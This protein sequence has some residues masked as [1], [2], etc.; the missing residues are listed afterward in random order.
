MT[1]A[2]QRLN[3][4]FNGDH[5]KGIHIEELERQII[6]SGYSPL[7]EMVMHL[8]HEDI[9]LGYF[10]YIQRRMENLM[11]GDSLVK[12]EDGWA[13]PDGKLVL[14]FSRRFSEKLL[15]IQK[16]GFHLQEVEIGFI[17]YW[18]GEDEKKEIKIILPELYFSKM[19]PTKG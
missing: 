5:F 8:N 2:K 13:N 6:R 14:K 18:K 4:Y 1:R 16:S 19:P 7:S 9:H 3:I 15:A 10:K 17:L 11:C 12:A